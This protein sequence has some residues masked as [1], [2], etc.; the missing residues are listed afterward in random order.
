MKL[1]FLKY[2]QSL[3][4][5]K[6]Y[7]SAQVLDKVRALDLALAKDFPEAALRLIYED[8]I[9]SNAEYFSPGSTLPETE[10]LRSLGLEKLVCYELGLKTSVGIAGIPGA[11]ELVKDINMYNTITSLALA[12]IDDMDIELMISGKY[13][14]HYTIDDI[15][16]FLIYFFNVEDWTLTEKKQYTNLIKNEQLKKFYEM[17]LDGDKDY[18][19]WKLGIAPDKSFDEMLRDM[20][21]D[22]YYNFK[23]MQ[24]KNSDVAQKWAGLSIKLSER[25]DKMEKEAEDRKTIFEQL[26]FVLTGIDPTKD[27]IIDKTGQI[28]YTKKRI[29]H[30]REL[31]D[32]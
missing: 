6:K 9:K 8:L 11:L 18:L 24:K 28:T 10:W 27:T 26:D 22:S 14:I 12:K 29:K 7:T 19:I 17:A 13:N 32:E 15:K 1:P 3:I 20:A 4:I 2:I 25:V 31:E 21:T 16:E 30:I 5:M 23:E